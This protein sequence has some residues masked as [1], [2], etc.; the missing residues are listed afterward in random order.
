MPA[1]RASVGWPTAAKFS[2]GTHSARRP[3]VSHRRPS[4]RATVFAA[5][6]A[7]PPA[8]VILPGLG[9][10][11]GDYDALKADLEKLQLTA[12]VA[13]VARIDWA[14]N[15]AGVVDMNYWKGT[16]CPTPTVN[17]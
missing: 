4:T 12:R 6:S 14:R 3:S 10:A 9:N 5:A 17:W 16:L 8:V 11:T 15:A 7:R 1:T 2:R 13:N